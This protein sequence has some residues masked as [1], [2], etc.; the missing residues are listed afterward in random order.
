MTRT[1]FTGPGYDW[2][3]VE[4]LTTSRQI[5]EEVLPILLAT[6]TFAFNFHEHFSL[7]RSQLGAQRLAYIRYLHFAVVAN[8]EAVAARYPGMIDYEQ[9]QTLWKMVAQEL[10]GLRELDLELHVSAGFDLE[11]WLAKM[12]VNPSQTIE[13]WYSQLPQWADDLKILQGKLRRARL[14]VNPEH[15]FGSLEPVMSQR[16]QEIVRLAERMSDMQALITQ[17]GKGGWDD[18]VAQWERDEQTRKD[19][20]EI[21][22][23]EREMVAEIEGL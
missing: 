10:T 17:D 18:V 20:E 9:W 22:Q 2:T 14:V 4:L 11:F 13:A 7:F 12:K 16:S 15:F 21:A 19:L 6:N 3:G 23:I 1:A 8:H 5:Y